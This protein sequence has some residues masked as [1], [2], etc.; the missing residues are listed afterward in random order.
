MPRAGNQALHDVSVDLCHAGAFVK[1]ARP[2][3]M[4]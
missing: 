1:L 2:G 4:A 3:A